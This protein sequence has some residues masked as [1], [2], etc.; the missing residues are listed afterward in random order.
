MSQDLF[1]I[2]ISELD[3][4]LQPL[5][6]A[7]DDPFWLDRILI[8][9]GVAA[10]YDGNGLVTALQQVL[11]LKTQLTAFSENDSPSFSDI[12]NLLDSAEAAFQS[13][14]ALSDSGQVANQFTDLGKDLV[15]WLIVVHLVL[16]HPVIFQLGVLLTVIEQQGDSA[17]LTPVVRDGVTTREAVLL[18]RLHPRKLI[19][20]IRDPRALLKTE[21]LNDL[22]TDADA[23][24]MADKFFRRLGRFL[25]VVGINWKYGL[26]PVNAA[27]LG[28][29]GPIVDHSMMVYFDQ[30][31]TGGVVDAGVTLSFSSKESGDLGLVVAPFGGVS[32]KKHFDDWTTE[33]DL[34]AEI[35]AFAY[36]R[37][38]ATIT[39]SAAN[40]QVDG[41]LSATLAAPDSG[42]AF[43]FGSPTGTRLEVG[44]AQLALGTSLSEKQQSL[45]VSALVSKSQIVIAKGDSDSFLANFLPQ[46][47]LQAKFDLGIEW[48]NVHGLTFHGAA[49]LDADIPVGLS[50]AQSI[51]V[52]TVHLGLKADDSGLTAEV[53]AALVLF[54]W[55]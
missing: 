51:S 23:H 35:E 52:P 14:R 47:G 9:L 31:S 29:A 48:S 54:Q 26:D 13:V 28:D 5:V 44:G 27:A 24:A 46:D 3:L 1:D 20:L 25:T 6:S 22:N 45:D 7:V 42:A 11:N 15:E 8:E 43:V 33:I 36:G 17:P 39:A 55:V 50:L 41:K 32:L 34:T 4:M 40:V 37:Q 30:Q 18:R 12:S 10:E 2:L 38:G 16:H 19:D 21:Y 49:G 53:S